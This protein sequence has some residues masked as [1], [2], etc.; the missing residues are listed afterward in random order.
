MAPPYTLENTMRVHDVAVWKWLSAFHVDYG[1]IAGTGAAAPRDDHPILRVFAAPQRAAATTVD[2]LVGLGWIAED[3]QA[4]MITKAEQDF[5]TLPLPL[6]TI[7]RTDPTPD[8]ELYGVPKVLR[9]KFLDTVTGKWQF[10]PWPGHYR[11]EYT[12]TFWSKKRYSE[13]H[14]R[15]WIYSELGKIGRN[16]IETLIPVEHGEPWGTWDQSFKFMGSS[17]L[18][19][20]EGVEQRYMR[21]EFNFSLRTWM[22]RA[23]IADDLTGTAFPIERIGQ[24]VCFPGT[25]FGDFT[26]DTDE[27]DSSDNDK[28]SDNLF[29]FPFTDH[30]MVTLWPREGPTAKVARGIIEPDGKVKNAFPDTLKISV[31]DVSD[32]V[33]IAE[34]LTTLDAA[35]NVIFGLSFNYVADGRVELEIKQR[36]LDVQPE[37]ISSVFSLIL[38]EA[39]R[40][41]KVHQFFVGNENTIISEI[42]GIIGEPEH[43]VNLNAI[44]L[45][46]IS[47]LDKIT[48]SATIDLGTEDRH[49]WTGLESEAYLI[50]LL[51]TSTIGGFNVVTAEDD[52]ATPAFT[53]QQTVDSSVNVGAVFLVQPKTDSLALRV[54]KTTTVASVYVQRYHG[55]YNGNEL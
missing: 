19:D 18:S 27:V 24:D 5:S 3:S 55:A 29:Y 52:V 6:V 1:E 17:D 44:D 25:G 21:F 43:T 30:Q 46:H 20:L 47:T 8:P 39:R 48:P 33:E 35:G 14:F 10:H 15:E 41:R 40:W 45:R 49:E 34:R 50:V 54:P 26:E 4:D 42:R 16:D 23:P 11:T 53:S 12:L 38:T 36:D 37:V 31:T 7:R 28:Q 51:I 13:V 9:R 32:A 2:L 22:M